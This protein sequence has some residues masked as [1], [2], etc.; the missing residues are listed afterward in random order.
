MRTLRLPP[1]LA[2]SASTSSA[3]FTPDPTVAPLAKIL[4]VYIADC[5]ARCGGGARG[6]GE[7][8][9]KGQAWRELRAEV[10]GARDFLNGV[11]MAEDTGVGEKKV[12]VGSFRREVREWRRVE[13]ERAERDKERAKGEGGRG[14]KGRNHG[15]KIEYRDH[16]FE[17]R[18]QTSDEPS[19]EQFLHDYDMRYTL[20]REL[21]ELREIARLEAKEVA[22]MEAKEAKAMEKE[23]EK[24]RARKDG[25]QRKKKRQDP[26]SSAA[27]FDNGATAFAKSQ[28]TASKDAERFPLWEASHPYLD[29][30]HMERERTAELSRIKARA[31]KEKEKSK[32]MTESSQR[33]KRRHH[34]DSDAGPFSQWDMNAA[35]SMPKRHTVPAGHLHETATQPPNAKKRKSEPATLKATRNESVLISSDEDASDVYI[36]GKP[37]TKRVNHHSG[38]KAIFASG[39][40]LADILLGGARK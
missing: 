32:A 8:D 11:L 30:R 21:D 24:E 20:S 38:P 1:A 15:S 18:M 37:S 19:R 5:Q 33:K 16:G 40:R 3:R 23:K 22:R 6:E 27:L 7:G 10:E 2:L 34:P 28:S 12:G 35:E 14:K 13:A 39:G 26:D 17:M 36:R 31:E 29:R 9:T 25:S 4:A